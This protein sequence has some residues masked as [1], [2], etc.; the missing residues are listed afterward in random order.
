MKK[1]GELL[2]GIVFVSQVFSSCKTSRGQAHVTTS[3]DSLHYYIDCEVVEHN[4]K[5]HD[6]DYQ[7]LDSNY[8]HS[9]IIHDHDN[10][11]YFRHS[12]IRKVHEHDTIHI[13]VNHI[14]TLIHNNQYELPTLEH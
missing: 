11:R 1:A 13:E 10:S 8:Y 14:D 7:I 6:L 4:L 5:S 3:V 9:L 12:K 2:L